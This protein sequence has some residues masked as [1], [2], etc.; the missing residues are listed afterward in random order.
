M[1]TAFVKV[2]F[3][4]RSWEIPYETLLL[5]SMN[6]IFKTIAS[7]RPDVIVSSGPIPDSLLKASI[8][9]RKRWI[10]L[11]PGTEPAA[12]SAAVEACYAGALWEHP[13][14]PGNPL[15]TVFTG[16]YNTGDF[17]ADTYQSLRLQTCPDWEWVVVDDESGDGTWERLLAIAAEDMRVRPIRMRHSGRIGA[18]K[19][20]ATQAACGSLLVELDHDDMLTCTA[21][22]EVARAFAEDPQAGLVYSNF[23][24]FFQDGRCNRYQGT[25][26]DDRYRETEY[27]GR[28][29]LEAIA[30]DIYGRFGPGFDQQY[31]YYLTVA[32][33]HLRAF[34]A[35]EL[36]RLG[37]WNPRL[38]VADD[39]DVLARFFLHSKCRHLDR[40][41]YLYRFLDQRGNTTFQRNKA[42]QDHLELGRAHYRQAFM[43]VNARNR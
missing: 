35:S 6:S 4:G 18:V 41:L 33:N 32:P 30:P 40:L 21:L 19:H 1:P 25:P 17:L 37:G 3:I 7:F 26:W 22:E 20:L 5:E 15:L 2:L 16:T 28:T 42:I 36:R 31:A 11:D 43:E 29:Y 23:A 10:H 13:A 34:R 12:V 9:L 39:W 27:L 38:P 14:D 24:E 8:E